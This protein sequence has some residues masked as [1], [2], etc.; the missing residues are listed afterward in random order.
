MASPDQTERTVRPF[1]A[2]LRKLLD[3]HVAMETGDE[4]AAD[5][6]RDEMDAPWWN[7]SEAE[8]TVLS[9][10]SDALYAD[11]KLDQAL[12]TLRNEPCE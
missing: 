5:N 2:Y 3:L 8:M 10:V 6:L 4:E 12:T 1:E 11:N 7:L 9:L